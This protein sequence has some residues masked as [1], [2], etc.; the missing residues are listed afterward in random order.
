MRQEP[1]SRVFR[2]ADEKGH[3]QRRGRQKEQDE[4]EK[5]EDRAAQLGEQ[6]LFR[7]PPAL[8]HRRVPELLRSKTTQLEQLARRQVEQNQG[9]RKKT[10]VD[11]IVLFW[12]IRVSE[13]TYLPLELPEPP[14][15]IAGN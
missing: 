2:S 6:A 13:S 7:A 1:I 3:E 15:L 11:R 10:W 5:E 9:A 4:E 12:Q 8:P 14:I